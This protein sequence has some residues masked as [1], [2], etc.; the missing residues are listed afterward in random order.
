MIKNSISLFVSQL[1]FSSYQSF[2]IIQTYPIKIT[3]INGILQKKREQSILQA[4]N[5][6]RRN[7]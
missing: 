2:I 6:N 5:N 4:L 3:R 1:N 7:R